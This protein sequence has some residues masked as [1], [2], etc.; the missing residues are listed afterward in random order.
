MLASSYR[1]ILYLPAWSKVLGMLVSNTQI[2]HSQSHGYINQNQFGL[3][4]RIGTEDA[5]HKLR[6]TIEN[7]H[8]RDK[9][10]CLVMLGAKITFNS[11]WN[12]RALSV[13]VI[14][15]ALRNSSIWLVFTF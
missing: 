10:S 7:C 13:L 3:T 12:P 15:N 9:D 4:M 5:L 1:P 6:Q 11:L 2:F 8:S 14:C